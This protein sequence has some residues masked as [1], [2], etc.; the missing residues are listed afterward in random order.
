MKRPVL[1]CGISAV[2]ICALFST[3]SRST[4]LAVVLVI[5]IPIFVIITFILKGK[6]FHY[7]PLLAAIILV[8]C[9]CFIEYGNLE[10]FNSLC[11][12]QIVHGTVC[13]KDKIGGSAIY[14]IKVSS[15]GSTRVDCKIKL[16]DSKG[17]ALSCGYSAELLTVINGI[18][19]K[20]DL[21]NGVVASGYLCD[22]YRKDESK[23][24]I[25]RI[26]NDFQKLVSDVLDYEI[27]G[28]ITGMSI[29]NRGAVP[30]SVGD[31]FRK[32]G[33]SHVLVVS[34]MHLSILVG[35]IYRF[36]AGLR[37]DRRRA[38]V[39]GI[40]CTLFLMALT[41]MSVSVVRAGLVYIIMFIGL[42]MRRSPDP[43]NSLFLALTIIIADNP[44]AI[45]SVSFQLSFAATFGVIVIVPL[46]RGDGVKKPNPCTAAG[47]YFIDS[48]LISLSASI[49]IMPIVVY[50][51]GTLNPVMLAATFLAVPLSTAILLFSAAA[52][53]S[54]SLAPVSM[55]FIAAAGLA[56]KL[57]ILISD[58]LGSLPFAYFSASNRAVSVIIMSALA[59]LWLAFSYAR[60]DKLKK[61]KKEE[62][63]NADYERNGFK[64][65]YR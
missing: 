23:S 10:N 44:F 13:E 12:K 53:L 43:I 11:G 26:G 17:R 47:E 4:A 62:Q 61:M 31:N 34:G 50:Y 46:L 9:L 39:I 3:V 30:A 65:K 37:M 56:A 40:A 8:S 36:L 29:G 14:T 45:F 7:I 60:Y 51:F 35:G 20:S 18:A 25:Y 58:K 41:G 5:T 32:T 27:A 55:V 19:P 15:I 42:I 28:T 33:I 21:G 59:L 6:I 52:A 49:M 57:M 22:V 64:K 24:F 38:G 1:L 2:F 63:K 54:F 16:I 48:L